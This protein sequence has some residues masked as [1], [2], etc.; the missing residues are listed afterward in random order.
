[1]G[2]IYNK[3]AKGRG[4]AQRQAKESKRWRELEKETRE[5]RN[6]SI[7]KLYSENKK[8]A[9]SKA[10]DMREKGGDDARKEIT[11]R[12]T[13][14]KEIAESCDCQFPVTTTWENQ[15]KA[16]AYFKKLKATRDKMR[17][18]RGRPF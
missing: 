1:M 8:F 14:L 7:R 13:A 10:A 9:T 4:Y 18:E 5:K 16:M 11:A 3:T 12:R 17:K 15:D 6:K 2:L